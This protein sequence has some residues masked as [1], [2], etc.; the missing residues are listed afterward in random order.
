MTENLLQENSLYTDAASRAKLVADKRACMDA[1]LINFFGF[2]GLFKLSDSRG[3]MKNYETTEGK[4]MLSSIGDTNHDVS[5]SV[6]LAFEAGI[7][8]LPVVNAMTKLLV[9]IKN[10]QIKSA[11]L[12]EQKVRDILDGVLYKQH[13]PSPT[14]LMAISNFHNGTISIGLLAKE[15]YSLCRTNKHL[16]PVTT[17]FRNLVMKGQYGDFFNKMTAAAHASA[18]VTSSPT[19][20]ASAQT[21]QA[22][23]PASVV[24]PQ[25]S[26]VV[27]RYTDT[28]PGHNKFWA[29]GVEDNKL[30]VVWGP[31]GSNNTKPQVKI[32]A[33]AA[34]AQ[35]EL[36]R[37]VKEKIGKGYKA[38]GTMSIAGMG[39]NT[40][41]A[42]TIAPTAIKQAPQPEKTAPP[43]TKIGATAEF[44]HELIANAK[45][46][47]NMNNTFRKYGVAKSTLDMNKFYDWIV[48]HIDSSAS[49]RQDAAQE[50]LSDVPLIK[51]LKTLSG[52]RK[53]VDELQKAWVRNSFEFAVTSKD[54]TYF[55]HRLNVSE[56]ASIIGKNDFHFRTWRSR[57]RNEYSEPVHDLMLS[58]VKDLARRANTVA[59]LEPVKEFLK[60]WRDVNMKVGSNWLAIENAVTWEE[61][62]P[63]AEAVKVMF[64]LKYYTNG[65]RNEEDC[66]AINFVFKGL[67][68]IAGKSF[69]WDD[70]FRAIIDPKF[71][72]ELVTVA[73]ARMYIAHMSEKAFQSINPKIQEALKMFQNLPDPIITVVSNDD[74]QSSLKD[75]AL[76]TLVEEIVF[77]LKKAGFI[78]WIAIP[79][80]QVVSGMSQFSDDEIFSALMADNEW[81]NYMVTEV[82]GGYIG[83]AGI[84]IKSLNSV[85][86][87]G[88]DSDVAMKRLANLGTRTL[89]QAFNEKH[90][91]AFHLPV[92][93]KLNL[94]DEIFKINTAGVLDA[95]ELDNLIWVHFI[96]GDA[97]IKARV[98]A[99]STNQ[100][101]NNS[102]SIKKL[103]LF[104]GEKHPE[105]IKENPQA[106]G[107]FIA[108]DAIVPEG[109][110]EVTVELLPRMASVMFEYQGLMNGN[111]EKVVANLPRF[112]N[113]FEMYAENVV[114]Q[115]QRSDDMLTVQFFGILA[116]VLGNG[117]DD[118]FVEY[119]KKNKELLG[120][121]NSARVFL[122]IPEHLLNNIVVRNKAMMKQIVDIMGNKSGV[123]ASMYLK[124]LSKDDV[125]S[126]LEDGTLK[127]IITSGRQSKSLLD[128]IVIALKEAK[129]DSSTTIALIDIMEE[130]FKDKRTYDK[131]MRIVAIEHI[132]DTLFDLRQTDSKTANEIFS[133]VKGEIKRAMLDRAVGEKLLGTMKK[134]LYG[135][136]VLIK[137]LQ[138]L[139]ADRIKEMLK[140]NNLNI[141][142]IRA[143]SPAGQSLDALEAEVERFSKVISH[144]KVTRG[145][146]TDKR[147]E[148][149]ER[150]SVEYDKFNKYRHG[151]IAVKFLDEFDV[152]IPEQAAGHERFKKKKPNTKTMNP[153]F[154]GTGSIAA[155][156][157]LRFGFAVIS[158]KDSSVVGRMLG[159]GIYFST[160]LDKVS[161]YVSDGGYSRGL[162]N[163]GYIFQMNALLGDPRIDY[164]EAG[165]G[166][167]RIV[168]PEWCVFTPNEQLKIEK[169]FLIEIISKD[170]MDRLKAKYP[171]VSEAVA[172]PI[173]TFKEFL[174]E[175]QTEGFSHTTTYAFI[176]GNIPVSET[177]YADFET[178]DVSKFPANVRMEPSG[179]GPMIIIDH[180]GPDTEAFCVDNTA[181]FMNNSEELIK[182][183][184]LAYN[185]QPR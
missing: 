143:N 52:Y 61:N 85:P 160:V 26:G 110:V 101:N 80:G 13:Q 111:F 118:K 73:K 119:V 105:F 76:K 170:A 139:D 164:R 130:M 35:A 167:D 165:T 88:N 141:P 56:F 33:N 100:Y 24:A 49:W 176:D 75:M 142:S 104:I 123:D 116:A 4:L 145:G 140:Y 122:G 151:A 162:G 40:S 117:M 168:S 126:K 9:L 44:F 17:E 30:F 89:F 138:Q 12:D 94:I 72:T 69:N 125:K 115:Y 114:T 163:K 179:V 171:M 39:T 38:D 136:D 166:G 15:L 177:E 103:R 37:L 184:K 54:P 10:K 41:P 81:V 173:I 79:T 2:L 14:I 183:L 82:W 155:S 99:T 43:L 127:T 107:H 48:D 147:A 65:M 156:M 154:H 42:I 181:R 106:I 36:A 137:P 47:A 149:L 55:T 45:D 22:A 131:S 182:F 3:Y 57:M 95:K 1:L 180:N 50:F 124:L 31:I 121:P 113:V 150:K 102:S 29:A 134:S 129:N 132:T 91:A 66:M 7:I 34:A 74:M 28:S 128:G 153:V 59:D 20:P 64:G 112:K 120:A 96:N 78:Q 46:G 23:T 68:S 11:D 133:S 92:N 159:D 86:R 185:H 108:N 77:L 16:I 90:P 172:A 87:Q 25:T 98:T 51:H 158:S 27:T 109:Q 8:M 144:P 71:M 18:P 93:S 62:T 21:N 5:L 67:K 174:K 53:V 83:K 178:I 175:S 161:Q 152:N 70:F 97:E 6:K 63:S 84:I 58:H 169:A 148:Y 32:L 60:K 146:E 135:E 157:I 19:T